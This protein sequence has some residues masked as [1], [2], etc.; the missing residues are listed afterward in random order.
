MT[1]HRSEMRDRICVVLGGSRGGG[2]GIAMALGDAGATVYVA[3]RTT[4]GGAAPADGAPGT[5]DD[6]A[7]EVT[8]RGGHGVPVVTDVADPA[9]IAALF[10]RIDAERGG[11][12][13]LLACASWSGNEPIDPAGWG[14]AF[15][16]RPAEVLG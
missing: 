9:S 10:D 14:A 11:R 2:R 1:D 5:I 12:L 7:D 6:T 13:D 4:R 15:W 8:R 16:D 3:G